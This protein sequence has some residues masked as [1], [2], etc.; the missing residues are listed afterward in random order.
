MADGVLMSRGQMWT[1]AWVSPEAVRPVWLDEGCKDVAARLGPRSRWILP[2]DFPA[3]PTGHLR[4][5]HPPGAERL[6]FQASHATFP[7]AFLVYAAG[8]YSNMGNYKS[9]GDTKFVPNLPKVS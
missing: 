2:P 5:C 3:T 8:V 9:F 4:G 6:C 7:Q 1:R